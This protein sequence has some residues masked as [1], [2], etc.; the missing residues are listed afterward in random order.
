M[1]GERRPHSETVR[2]ER[3][4]TPIR[5]S[6]EDSMRSAKS[7]LLVGA[8]TASLFAACSIQDSEDLDD[9]GGEEG[10]GGASAST[11]GG[12]EGQGGSNTEGTPGTVQCGAEVCSLP[13]E[14]CCGETS[15]C[16]PSADSCPEVPCA[17]FCEG[18]G[19]M[20]VVEI[21]CD[22]AADCADG[23][24]CCAEYADSNHATIACGNAPCPTY[25]VCIP[26][27][28]CSDGLTCVEALPKPTGALCVGDDAQVACGEMLCDGATP[29]CCGDAT[30]DCVGY[31]DTS[32]GVPLSCNDAA[33]CGPGYFCCFDGFASSCTSECTTTTLCESV[34]DCPSSSTAC[35]ADPVAAYPAG[36]KSCN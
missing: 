4:V 17:F 30:L 13:D 28:T 9:D 23:Q 15:A 10:S 36:F 3:Q 8:V 35:E 33:D 20:G 26:D 21:S 18:S 29:V 5:A 32:C 19:G 31:D 27:G 24:V 7:L 14:K 25:E 12:A 16:I 6:L 11:G 2:P 1:R 34:D 22:D